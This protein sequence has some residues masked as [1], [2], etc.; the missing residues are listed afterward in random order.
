MS[1]T[2]LKQTVKEKYGQAALR[3]EPACH[4][5]HHGRKNGR[6]GAADRQTEDQLKLDERCRAARQ[7]QSGGQ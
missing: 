6:G 5:G 7:R 2:E 1:A 4:A 3:V